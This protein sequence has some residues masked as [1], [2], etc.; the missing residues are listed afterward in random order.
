M[1]NV[2]MATN[3]S[4]R[5][6][7]LIWASL[8]A[9]ISGVAVFFNGYGV[10]AW[11]EVADATTYTTVKNV[12]AALAIVIIGLLSKKPR[13]EVAHK[14][15]PTGCDKLMLLLIAV[16]GGAVPFVLFFEGL[17][18]ATATQA[19]F[20]H[21]SLVIWVAILASVFLREKLG[22]VQL[23]AIGLLIGGQIAM[24][25]DLGAIAWARG[26]WMILAA[27]LMWSVEVVVAKRVLTRVPARTV[28]AARMIGGSVLLIG[29]VIVRGVAVDVAALRAEDWGWVLIAAGF[30][31][32]YVMTWLMALSL[33]PAVD[34]TAVLVAGAVITAALQTA[35]RGAALPNPVG[36]VLLIIGV[37]LVAVPWVWRTPRRLPR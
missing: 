36:L 28:A 7:G 17:A 25:G 33:A 20:I 5:R 1:W 4:S 23:V 26:E 19:A 37:F 6:T 31:A 22:P 21:K 2:A 24:V 10:R 32:A 13:S 27:T 35:V 8:T 16:V 3:R 15:V 14:G 30:L 12:V 18:Q 29:Y 9:V 34:V 11:A